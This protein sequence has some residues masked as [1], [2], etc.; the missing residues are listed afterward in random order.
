MTQDQITGNII[1][2]LRTS[3]KLT[4]RDFAY[5]FSDFMQRSK[6]YKIPTISSWEVGRKFPPSNVLKGLSDFFGV[7]VEY[8]LGRESKSGPQ[9]IGK[10]AEAISQ[11]L[12]T[13]RINPTDLPDYHEHPVFLIFEDH[14]LKDQ[15]ALVDAK[16]KQFIRTS[17]EV[18]P[19]KEINNHGIECHIIQP[20]GGIEKN[21]R[22][23][24]RNMTIDKVITEKRVWV[25]MLT[26]DDFVR[27]RYNGWFYI[28]K[29]KTCLVNARGDILPFEGLGSSYCAYRT[30][31]STL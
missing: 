16:R 26:Y 1:K 4:Q 23:E 20:F 25:E 7:S 6:T 28:N 8:L 17:G 22:S 13:T 2:Q 18:V 11:K 14:I 10:E 24:K 27:G 5:E 9:V 21:A 19:F 15:W 12:K 29:S 30:P 3:R 31:P